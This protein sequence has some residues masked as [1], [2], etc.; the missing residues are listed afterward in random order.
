MKDSPAFFWDCASYFRRGLVS[1]P[2]VPVLIS[3][4]FRKRLLVQ[5]APQLVRHRARAFPA[6]ASLC[7]VTASLCGL[8]VRYYSLL[9]RLLPSRIHPRPGHRLRHRARRRPRSPA[10]PHRRRAS[11]PSSRRFRLHLHA[12]TGAEGEF[13]L[14]QAPIGVYRLT[15]AAPGFATV[16]EPITVASGTNPVLHIPLSIAAATQTVTVDGQQSSVSAS[17]PSPPPPSS[18]AQ[19]STRLPAP[20]APSA[21]R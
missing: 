15:V 8:F 5:P 12:T 21:W 18:P 16:I 20:T 19:I 3:I 2:C 7:E 11:H 4:Y 10:P 17:T 9:S 1:T 6:A 13:E 14:P